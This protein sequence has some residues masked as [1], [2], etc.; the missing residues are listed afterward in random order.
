MVESIEVINFSNDS[1]PLKLVLSDPE[2][3]ITSQGFAVT[4]VTGLGPGKATVNSS[5]L[6][7]IDGAEFINARLPKR[8]IKID[9][10]F[11]PIA[12]EK[13]GK[14]VDEAYYTKESGSVVIKL[15][16][17]YLETLALGD[18]TLKVQFNDGSASA[19]FTVADKS[20]GG[21][22]DQGNDGKGVRT[23][24]D[25]NILLWITLMTA[26]LL[27]IVLVIVYNR[28]KTNNS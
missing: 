28:R 24:D 13:D 14:R 20:A 5:E 10:T 3:E 6:V 16:P 23:G 26:S 25:S 19:R 1:K 8:T 9:L 15:K 21:G 27:A 18:H 2:N 22:K 17:T 4:S 7:T 11:L 12:Y